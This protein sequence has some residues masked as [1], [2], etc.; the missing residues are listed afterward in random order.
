MDRKNKLD[1]IGLYKVTGKILG[2]GNFAIVHEAI[3]TTLGTKVRCFF[4]A[5]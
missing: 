5:T 3:H 4:D 2:R 1:T